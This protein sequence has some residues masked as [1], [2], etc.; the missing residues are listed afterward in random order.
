MEQIHVP[1]AHEITGGSPSIVVGDIDTGLDYTHPDLAANVD[2]ANSVS[3]VSGVRTRIRCMDGQHGHGTHTAGTIAAAANGIGIIGVAPSV[4]IAGIK[5]GNDDGYFFPEA[6]HLLLHVGGIARHRR[7]QQQLL[8]RPL[9]F[10][11]ATTPSNT[12][13]GKPSSGPSAGLCSTA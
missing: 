5:A 4:K 12:P 7:H 6:G 13:S 11:C 3:C 8:R 9:L 1:E 10:N 2:F